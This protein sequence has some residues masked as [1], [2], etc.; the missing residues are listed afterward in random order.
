MAKRSGLKG[1]GKVRK[2]MRA[3]PDECRNELLREM[4]YAAPAILAHARREA[5]VRTGGLRDALSYKVY[6]RTLRLV[7]GLLGK[8]KNRKFFYGHILEVGRKAKTVRRRSSTGTRHDYRV[9]E[10]SAGQYDMVGPRTKKFARLAL[11]PAINRAFEKALAK[12]T[13][14]GGGA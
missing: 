2:V 10:I 12:A 14:K 5:P 11:R 13:A 9:T 8:A 6:P 3:L 1:V 7:V 4:E